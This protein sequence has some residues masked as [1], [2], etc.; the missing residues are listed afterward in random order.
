MKTFIVL[1]PVIFF[2]VAFIIVIGLLKKEG[3]NGLMMQRET[4]SKGE[5]VD[6]ASMS[7]F[8][9]LLSGLAAIILGV[10][11]VTFY[12]YA[13]MTERVE[14]DV[15]DTEAITKVILSLGIGVIPYATNQ[16]K[17]LFKN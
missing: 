15:E 3:I 4:N 2:T 1:L 16:L 13:A 12:L 17:D 11:I 14:F 6:K 7:R 8:V 9:L 10:S 5:E